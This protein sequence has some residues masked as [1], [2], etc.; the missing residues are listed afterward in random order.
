MAKR[1]HDNSTCCTWHLLSPDYQ[2]LL[3]GWDQIADFFEAIQFRPMYSR[4]RRFDVSTL[5]RLAQHHEM[6]ISNATG[7][8]TAWGPA[9]LWWLSVQH[10]EGKFPWAPRPQPWMRKSQRR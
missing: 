4:R 9:L 5:V 2:R 8:I 6:P 10:E 3:H 7:R 1:K